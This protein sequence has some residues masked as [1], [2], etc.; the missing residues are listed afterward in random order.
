[1]TALPIAARPVAGIGRRIAAFGIDRLPLVLGGAAVVALLL[2]RLPTGSVEDV[3]LPLAAFWALSFLYGLGLWWWLATAGL[4]PGKRLLGMRVVSA[5]TAR[6]I[7]WGPAFLR[8]LV[9]GLVTALT[10]GV[11]ALV[12]AAVAA[13]DPRRRGWHDRAAGSVVVDERAAQE[14]PPAPAAP[15][16]TPGIVPV[17]LPAGAALPRPADPALPRPADPVVPLGVPPAPM[18]R[19]ARVAAPPVGPPAAVPLVHA[20]PRA[21][22]PSPSAGGLISTVPGLVDEVPGVGR[23]APAAPPSS[24]L[25]PQP[26]QQ[27]DDPELTRMPVRRSPAIGDWT[28]SVGGRRIRVVGPGLLGR[29]PQPRPGEEVVHLVPV[30]DPQRSL[31]KTHLSFGVDD[32][33]FWVCDRGSTNGTTVRTPAGDRQPCPPDTPVRIVAGSALLVGDHEISIGD[34][35]PP[36]AIG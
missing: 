30:D 1:M 29:D 17:G 18:P 35:A 20:A 5:R 9:L 25:P 10:L 8:Q 22:P 31:S 2:G 26:Q 21:A 13:R 11:G 32:D 16:T 12:L 27:E 6:P 24:P 28:L 36:S 23:S 4:S 34:D 33:G 7:G 3:V 19:A 15:R 14:P